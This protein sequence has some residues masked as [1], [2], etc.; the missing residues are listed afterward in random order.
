MFSKAFFSLCSSLV[1]SWTAFSQDL[2]F[3]HG[4]PNENVLYDAG[5]RTVI[6]PKIRKDQGE[7]F[8]LQI[9]NPN[10][11]FYNYDIKYQQQ[12]LKSEDKEITDLFSMLNTILASRVSGGPGA[13]K[14]LTGRDSVQ[15]ANYKAAIDTLTTDINTAKQY[16][17]NS[18]IPEL[19]Q[20]ALAQ[21]RSG[22]LRNA[23]D[24]INAL[25]NGQFHFNS[26]TLLNDLTVLSNSI[27][28]EPILKESLSLLNQS[29]VQKVEDI[30]KSINS[31]SLKTTLLSQFTVTDKPTKVVLTIKRIDPKNET[32]L[33]YFQQVPSDTIILAT[34]LPNYK[35]ATLELIPVANFIFARE[36]QEFYVENNLMQSRSKRQTTVM[37]GIILNINLPPFGASKE[38]S[39][40]IG[41][42]YKFSSDGKVLENFYLSALFSY[43]NIIRIGIGGGFAQFPYGLKEGGQIGKPLPSNISNLNDLLQYEEK[44]AAFLT[45]AFTGLNLTKK[46]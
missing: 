33:R 32:L 9:L 46:K 13:A 35:R 26:G 36:V 34:I 11:L 3:F 28:I 37:P 12:E 7:T 5:S 23:I 25:S 10:P 41:P 39:F 6:E 14:R 17:I 38:F 19:P 29:R 4:R 43:K 31:Q 22:G 18:D 40:G 24:R 2:K 1:L 45:I 42:G 21:R 8:S 30:K 27:N 16:I 20:D 44:P 15:L